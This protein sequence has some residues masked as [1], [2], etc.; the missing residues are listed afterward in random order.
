[1]YVRALRGYEKA[2]GL[3]HTSTLDTV[4]NLGNLYA[5]QGKIVEAEETYVRALRGYEKEQN[6]IEW[7]YTYCKPS[8]RQDNKICLDTALSRVSPFQHWIRLT[9]GSTWSMGTG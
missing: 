5:D 3:E 1:M 4:N 6:G 7:R 8:Y 9:L 2:W